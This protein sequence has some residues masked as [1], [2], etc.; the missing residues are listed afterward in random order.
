MFVSPTYISEMPVTIFTNAGRIR[1]MLLP[2]KREN[3]RVNQMQGTDEE[4]QKTIKFCN[5]WVKFEL[6]S[7][8]H[9]YALLLVV[10]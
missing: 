9:E 10:L 4:F 3:G 7:P 1:T 2:R 8:A 5:L 6:K